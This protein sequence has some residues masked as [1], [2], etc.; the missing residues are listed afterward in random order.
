MALADSRILSSADMMSSSLPSPL[1]AAPDTMQPLSV[2]VSPLGGGR[3]NMFAPLSVLPSLSLE[4]SGF[5]GLS[6]PV[7]PSTYSFSPLGPFNMDIR[8]PPS[9]PPLSPTGGGVFPMPPSSPGPF[10]PV[11]SE[12]AAKLGY[13]GVGEGLFYAPCLSMTPTPP[14]PG[15]M[16][17]PVPHVSTGGGQPPYQFFNSLTDVSTVSG[18]I[19]GRDGESAAQATTKAAAADEEA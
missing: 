15:L 10:S 4:S 16:A 8:A 6:S 17:S 3:S 1:A 5:A 12:A 11:P 13:S 7:S 2:D 9:A 18:G 19:H 14:P